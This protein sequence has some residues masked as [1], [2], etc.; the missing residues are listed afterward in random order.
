M[1]RS[2]SMPEFYQI[3][4]REPLNII[5][6]R[7]S[8]EYAY[9]HVPTAV[10]LPL[11]GFLTSYTTLEKDKEYYLICQSGARSENA[12]QFLGAQGY[13]VINVM[14]GTSAWMGEL[15]DSE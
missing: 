4:K 10:N 1:F 8:D 12:C 5:D 9:G 11:S 6:V 15:D 3:A 13:D 7:E 2:I 14:G